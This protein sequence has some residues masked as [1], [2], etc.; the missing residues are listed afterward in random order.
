MAID[1]RAKTYCNL[2]TIIS[3]DFAD[4]YLQNNGLVKTVG[5]LK[6]DGIHTPAVG[7]QI[8]F[9]Y[10][11]HGNLTRLPRV[12]RVLSSFADPYRNTTDISMGCLLSLLDQL[13]PPP[14]TFENEV[15][16]DI[17]IP[18]VSA[19]TLANWVCTQI[20]LAHG[21]FP[22]TNTYALNRLTPDNGFIA[23]LSDLLVSE[24]FV[25]YLDETET[26]RFIDLSS[27]STFGP[28]LSN[29]EVI[30]V[31]AIGAGQLPAQSVVVNYSSLRF[32]PPD[33]FAYNRDWELDESLLGAT[34]TV[35]YT[36]EVNNVTS[37][38]EYNYYYTNLSR[39]QTF[40]DGLDRVTKRVETRTRSLGEVNGQWVGAAMSGP[41]GGGQFYATQN[42]TTTVTTISEYVSN[43]AADYPYCNMVKRRT[44]TT[45]EDLRTVAGTLGINTYRHPQTNALATLPSGTVVTSRVVEDYD[46][47]IPATTSIANEAGKVEDYIYNTGSTKQKN[48][49]Y[50]SS[51]QTLPGQ[52]SLRRRLT[53]IENAASSAS[54]YDWQNAINSTIYGSAELSL[55]DSTTQI[56][57][58]R[59]FGL[60]KRPSLQDRLNSANRKG[61]TTENKA[62]L[63]WIY[64][65][66]ASTSYIEFSMPLASDDQI[67]NGAVIASDAGAKAL[68]FGRAQNALLLGNRN[69]MNM[70]LPPELLPAVPFA[71]LYFTANGATAQYRANANS[72]T[73]DASGLVCSTDA[74][75]WGGITGNNNFWYPTAPNTTS[76]SITA[77][78]AY[79][80]TAQPANT[81]TTPANFD[82]T[83]SDW[84][85]TLLPTNESPT[86]PTS[87]T[88]PASAA[89]YIQTITLTPT[90]QVGFEAARF[91][92][93]LAFTRTPAPTPLQL[94]NSFTVADVRYPVPTPLRL[95]VG[96]L[97][98][99]DMAEEDN[100]YG[101]WSQQNYDWNAY[102]RPGKWGA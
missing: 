93:P 39:T 44:T 74:L 19:A 83:A 79:D 13:K 25:G 101:S 33:P 76:I 91:D 34:Y 70:Q 26:L 36:Q 18:P 30:D 23:L 12:M 49:N 82:P 1:L 88:P 97:V 99:M 11:K 77:T 5:N 54:S 7:T 20:G 78:P 31:G 67:V 52:Q 47:I 42:V 21:T 43:S 87:V 15:V 59:E 56:V 17:S 68:R 90:L 84:I 29:Q 102:L 96:T 27:G 58:N 75:F 22:L 46:T 40:Y 37:S 2:G 53:S 16:I 60:E 6:L 66:P 81:I 89:P 3:G 32:K 61:P 57:T 9:A 8:F 98:V 64:G 50:A 65:S 24:S 14:T 94:V 62:E 41:G 35:A 45:E 10:E 72:W 55:I 48:S 63:Q 92:Y 80:P 86:F 28:L 71:P 100:F 85:S 69:G 95:S 73:F 38:S 51:Y 4:D